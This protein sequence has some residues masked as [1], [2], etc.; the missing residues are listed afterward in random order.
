M[1]K[2]IVLFAAVLLGL[3][4]CEA[5]EQIAHAQ[6][7]AVGV[8]AN[9]GEARIVVFRNYRSV[10][11]PVV[12]TIYID[13][14]PVGKS[15]LGTVFARDVAPGPHVI[16]TDLKHPEYAEVARVNLPPGGTV[17]LGVDDN[18]VANDTQGRETPVFSIAPI[19]PDIAAPQA[20]RLRFVSR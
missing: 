16:T 11:P 2:R 13:G 5:P 12:P 9:A 15:R 17:Y 19:D 1:R 7:G 10:R 4:G 20:S 14:R 3:V 18:W 8:P 6:A